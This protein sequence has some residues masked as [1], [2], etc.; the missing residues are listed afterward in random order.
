MKLRVGSLE[1]KAFILHGGELEKAIQDLLG[2]GYLGVVTQDRNGAWLK[3]TSDP[4]GQIIFRAHD[5]NTLQ[6]I[7]EVDFKAIKDPA[8]YNRQSE[9]KAILEKHGWS[10]L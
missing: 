5:P 9:I 4:K 8:L 10:H 1:A 7:V 3:T 6:S 2:L